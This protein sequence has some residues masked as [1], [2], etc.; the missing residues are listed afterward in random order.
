LAR[1]K[2]QGPELH[3]KVHENWG[4]DRYSVFLG[5]ERLLEEESAS[6]LVAW[7]EGFAAGIGRNR[8]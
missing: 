1:L 8:K 7:L 3:L 5:D 2:K 4:G 6:W